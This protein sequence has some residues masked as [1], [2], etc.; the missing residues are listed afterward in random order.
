M[1]QWWIFKR[2]GRTKD[3]EEVCTNDGFG[4]YNETQILSWVCFFSVDIFMFLEALFFV[5]F[6]SLCCS[7]F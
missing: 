5:C 1:V 4:F 7:F 3:H 2:Q 6:A